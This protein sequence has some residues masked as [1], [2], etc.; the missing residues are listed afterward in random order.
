MHNRGIGTTSMTHDQ[1]VSSNF[2]KWSDLIMQMGKYETKNELQFQERSLS[3]SDKTYNNNSEDRSQV[4][5]SQTIKTFQTS[6]ARFPF[7]TYLESMLMH[8]WSSVL[9]RHFSK[10]SMDF[11]S[12]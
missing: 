7:Q 6:A 5:E 10:F 4:A 9:T 8:P 11:N 2:K 3:C 12:Q 1:S